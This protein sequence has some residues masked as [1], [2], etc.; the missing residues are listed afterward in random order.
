LLVKP[1][2]RNVNLGSD[3]FAMFNKQRDISAARIDNQI[4]RRKHGLAVV[5]VGDCCHRAVAIAFGDAPAFGEQELPILCQSNAVSAI[6][7][8]T[9][10]G[11]LA[12]KI[13]MVS[14][15]GTDI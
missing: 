7:V 4:V 14:L 5:V 12:G 10:G 8:P 15:V 2:P 13:K 6:S 9:H 3:R 11:D 1:T